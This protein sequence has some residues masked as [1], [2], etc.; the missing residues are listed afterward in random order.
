MMLRNLFMATAWTVV[1]LSIAIHA[2]QPAVNED[3]Q[4]LAALDKRLK[5]YAALHEK[6]HSTLPALSNDAKPADIDKNQRALGALVQK[7]R[8]NAE[9]GD[10]FGPAARAMIRRI[11]ARALTGPD[12]AKLKAS[13]MDEN[14]GPLKIR[15][16]S[17]YPDAAPRSSV[18][19][20]V[21]QLLP[22][23][24]EDLDYRFIADRLLL[25]DLHAH[26]VVDYIENA[27]P[28]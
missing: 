11:L 7:A 20:Q 17:R 3:A 10:I 5:D 24:P 21:L 13:I 18:P 2:A 25:V 23:L 16:N 9:R 19:P 4:I 8:R 28:N 26:I 6:L 14:P 27:L 12:G 15:V 22:K 1:T